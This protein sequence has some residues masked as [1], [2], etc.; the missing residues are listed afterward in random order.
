MKL[1]ID[2]E[3][4][5]I[6]VKDNSTIGEIIEKLKEMNILWYEFRLIADTGSG[7]TIIPYYPVSP[8]EPLRF[9][10]YPYYPPIVTC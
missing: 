1:E 10:T 7:N 9:P 4:K 3:A 6:V 5:T 8:F 2:F